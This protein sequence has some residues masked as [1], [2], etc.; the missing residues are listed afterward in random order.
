MREPCSEQVS[1]ELNALKPF[2]L[3]TLM[4]QS[5]MHRSKMTSREI[6]AILSPFED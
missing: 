3:I 2:K 5:K 6:R 4:T 1:C